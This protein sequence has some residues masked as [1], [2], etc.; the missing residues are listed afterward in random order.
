M[1][2]LLLSTALI[3]AGGMAAASDT[4]AEVDANVNAEA[5]VTTDMSA[6][7]SLENAAEQAANDVAD[8]ANTVKEEVTDAANTVKEETAEALND[9]A[10]ATEE[11]A[12]E[13]KM[14]TETFY[15][16]DGMGTKTLLASH[17]IGEYVYTSETD[18]DINANYA[19]V[20]R[21]WNNIGEVRDI[22]MS[23]D[24]KT[25]SILLDIGGFLGIGEHTV[26]INMDQLVLVNDADDEG[27]FFVVV[28]ATK[29][30]LMN[31][32]EFDYDKVG[33]WTSKGDM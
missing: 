3:F 21:E 26:A 29:E 16:S 10:E 4:T 32:P 15:G 8:A 6:A 12:A 7:E 18:V 33:A 24:G 13:A 27:D 31:A 1:K 25:R 17:L 11:M 20:D 2:K 28:K 23:A 14:E 5:Q 22:V 9:T 30:E 19:D